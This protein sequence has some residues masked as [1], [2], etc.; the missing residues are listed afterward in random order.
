ILEALEYA[1]LQGEGII[2]VVGEVGSGKTTLCRMLEARLGGQVETVFI[3]N[4]SLTPENIFHA[5]AVELHIE[6]A[7]KNDRFQVL[8]ALQAYLLQKHSSGRHV[9]VLVEEAQ[10]MPLATLEE[11][12]LLSN[13]ETSSAKLLQLVLF[14]QPELD[15]NLSVP[16]IRQLKERISYQFYLP[17]FSREDVEEYLVMRMRSAGYRGPTPFTSGACRRIW[18]L[19]GGL[20]RRINLLA[21]KALLAAYIEKKD[22][23][24]AHHV[25]QAASESTF[26]T[27]RDWRRTTRITTLVALIGVPM[28]GALG[29]FLAD[30]NSNRGPML[31]QTQTPDSQP[32]TAI[33]GKPPATDEVT[34]IPSQTETTALKPTTKPA[35]TVPTSLAVAVKTE[36]EPSPNNGEGVILLPQPAQT[37][38]PVPAS[39]RIL[40]PLEKDRRPVPSPPTPDPKEN[41]GTKSKPSEPH[42]EPGTS[43]TSIPPPMTKPLANIRKESVNKSTLPS[44]A[45]AT[46]GEPGSERKTDVP[47]REELNRFLDQRLAISDQW[48]KTVDPKHY[49]LQ[50]MRVDNLEEWFHDLLMAESNLG[51]TFFIK[52]TRYNDQSFYIVYFNEYSSYTKARLDLERLPQR[53][54]HFKPFVQQLN[55]IN[56]KY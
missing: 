25:N 36:P 29:Y 45:K 30:F 1:I 46:P 40:G 51:G 39:T 17:P 50:I 26:S 34:Q 12:R 10:G 21:D 14:G 32:Q 6:L 28:A 22:R 7:E 55:S 49:T 5:I 53:L 41:P 48:F 15:I 43:M 54:H 38:D 31:P 3:A 13:L 20:T 23:V 52:P 33:L 19:S 16:S 9:V 56:D 24:T 18:K 44:P 8:Q 42:Q 37:T 35:G 27:V 4:P 47:N 11:I 2:K